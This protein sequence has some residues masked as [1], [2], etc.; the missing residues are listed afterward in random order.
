MGIKDKSKNPISEKVLK[1]AKILKVTELE[2]F[3]WLVTGG[4][5]PHV[6]QPSPER[7][8]FMCDCLAVRYRRVCS[9]VLAVELYLEKEVDN[10]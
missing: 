3:T 5:E 9:H 7:G 2:D 10:E 1:K 6:V 4:S 8:G